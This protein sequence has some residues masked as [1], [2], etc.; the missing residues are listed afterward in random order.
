M[1]SE[2]VC[3]CPFGLKGDRCEL[4]D[5]S[6]GKC[7]EE[8]TFLSSFFYQTGSTKQF[9]YFRRDSVYQW[10]AHAP[11]FQSLPVNL[12]LCLCSWLGLIRHD[13]RDEVGRDMIFQ[14]YWYLIPQIHLILWR[15]TWYWYLYIKCVQPI[16]AKGWPISN[17]MVVLNNILFQPRY[18]LDPYLPI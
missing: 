3:E 8:I 9:T 6:E 11:P 5:T 4:V 1:T 14:I 15:P 2:C 17:F 18:W 10:S 13:F 7:W 12:F 16:Y